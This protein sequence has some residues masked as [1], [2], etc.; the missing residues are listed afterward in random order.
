[1]KRVPDQSELERRAAKRRKRIAKQKRE[2]L[3]EVLYTTDKIWGVNE[4]RYDDPE[5]VALLWLFTAFHRFVDEVLKE[6]DVDAPARRA[7]CAFG[8]K[9]ID[10]AC[11]GLRAQRGPVINAWGRK[12]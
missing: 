8:T 9:A 4:A 6:G 1:M 7:A 10:L 3:A 11:A 5:L 2:I 12:T